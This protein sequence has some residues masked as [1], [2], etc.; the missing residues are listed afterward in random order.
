MTCLDKESL[1]VENLVFCDTCNGSTIIV[2][3][4]LEAPL[5][6]KKQVD[7]PPIVEAHFGF[8]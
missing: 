1:R 8:L 3:P 7:L 4:L 6:K 5:L 2:C